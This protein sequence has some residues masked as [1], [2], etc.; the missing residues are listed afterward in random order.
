[1][2]IK[3]TRILLIMLTISLLSCSQE[4]DFKM[5]VSAIDKVCECEEVLADMHSVGLTFSKDSQDS[6]GE[7]Y[8]LRLKAC[9]IENLEHSMV[10]IVEELKGKSLCDNVFIQLD[11][12]G[13]KKSYI[14]KDCSITLAE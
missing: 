6:F 8:E 1:M 2:K 12:E 14:I 13:E 9:E 11:F 10:A 4:K 7:R 3:I 5:I